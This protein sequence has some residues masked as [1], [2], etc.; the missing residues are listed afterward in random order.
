MANILVYTEFSGDHVKPVTLEIIGKLNG[1]SIDVAG[2]GDIPAPAIE[3]LAKF[4]AENIHS[5]KGENLEIYSPEG[6][7]NALKGF[8]DSKSYDYVFSGST[9]LAKDLIPRLAGLL[10][11]GMASEV[12]S[13]LFEINIH[14]F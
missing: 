3:E 4:G 13:F 12:T 9:A 6:Y 10:T 1:H 11:S 8:I 7:S 2:F 5:L 14:C